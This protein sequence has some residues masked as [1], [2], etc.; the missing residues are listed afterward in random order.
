[1]TSVIEGGTGVPVRLLRLPEVL[2]RTGL[3][4][5]TIY[6]RLEQGRFPRPVS[7]GVRAVGW[8]ESEVDEWIRERIAESRDGAA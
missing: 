3:S 2:A 4:R 5:S 7:L 8:I 1:M 6:V